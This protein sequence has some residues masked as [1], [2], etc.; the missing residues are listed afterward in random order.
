MNTL[1]KKLKIQSIE[2]V[3]LWKTRLIYVYINI[4]DTKQDWH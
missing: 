2:I 3:K 1:S 4:C